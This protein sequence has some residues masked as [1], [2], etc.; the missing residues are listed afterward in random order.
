MYPAQNNFV[1]FMS[2]RK[3]LPVMLM[4]EFSEPVPDT[5]GRCCPGCNSIR[6]V[7][8]IVYGQPTPH[9]CAA[10]RKGKIIVIDSRPGAHTLYCKNCGTEW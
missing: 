10:Q 5:T 1:K 9:L 6:D 7:I 3:V 2:S 8:P 4:Q